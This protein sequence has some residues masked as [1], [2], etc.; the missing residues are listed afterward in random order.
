MTL[1]LRLALVALALSSVSPAVQERFTG[2]VVSITDGDTIS[3]MQDGRVVTVRLD[4]IDCQEKLRALASAR[5]AM[6]FL[7]RRAW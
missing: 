6:L 4:G 5:N 3:V 7:A 2:K 1:R